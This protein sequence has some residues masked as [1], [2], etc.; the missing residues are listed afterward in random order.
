[1]VKLNVKLKNHITQK[2]DFVTKSYTFYINFLYK[3]V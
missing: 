2:G 1:M 3:K